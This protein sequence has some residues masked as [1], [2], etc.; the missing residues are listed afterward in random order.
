MGGGKVIGTVSLH[1]LLTAALTRKTGAKFTQDASPPQARCG[2][3]GQ[4]H[5]KKQRIGRPHVDRVAA[6]R[7]K[8]LQGAHGLASSW[9][10][11]RTQ[12]L[13]LSSASRS[14]RARPN[15]LAA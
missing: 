7:K 4:Q 1:A 12:S 10:I 9:A 6:H 3:I 11:W 8:G 15:R 2:E 5:H 13:P 14:A